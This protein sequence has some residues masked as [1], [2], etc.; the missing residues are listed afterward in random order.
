MIGPHVN[1]QIPAYA[2]DCLDE[3]EAIQVEAHL[4]VCA[5]CRA[6]LEAYK[7]TAAYL[8]LVAPQ[9][10]PPLR[11]K[12][13]I[14]RQVKEPQAASAQR[15][16]QKIGTSE[17]WIRVYRSLAASVM[18]SGPI[19][20]G[21]SLLLIIALTASNIVL[22]RQIQAQKQ[23]S[24]FHLVAL[25][26]TT[27]APGASGM[28]VISQEGLAGTVIV[29]GLPALSQAHQYQ[30]WLM[31]DGKRTSGGLFY[32]GQGGYG[33]LAVQSPGS[34]L[35]FSSFGITVEPTGGSPGPTGAKVLGGNL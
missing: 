27:N 33:I 16:P 12:A 7:A 24:E 15:S 14:L 31:K 23:N 17:L 5:A 13:S 26:G 2:L 28:M 21:V 25:K 10:Q 8:G 35:D 32:V 6:E 20:V 1:D 11:L 18:N 29:D 3:Q 19:L 22:Y 34:L 4:T 30:L 9:V